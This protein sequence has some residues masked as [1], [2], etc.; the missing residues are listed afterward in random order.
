[1]FHN[2]V[3]VFYLFFRRFVLVCVFLTERIRLRAERRQE[4]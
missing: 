4:S 1:M 2:C 3:L